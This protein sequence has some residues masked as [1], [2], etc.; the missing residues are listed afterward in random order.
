[1]S[2]LGAFHEAGL[3]HH[4]PAQGED[5]ALHCVFYT[6]AAFCLKCVVVTPGQGGRGAGHSLE[7]WDPTLPVLGCSDIHEP[8]AESHLHE[9]QLDILHQDV[10][11]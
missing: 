1:M 5:A 10:V 3:S 8:S 9:G 6:S 4:Q 11:P 7:L 2:V